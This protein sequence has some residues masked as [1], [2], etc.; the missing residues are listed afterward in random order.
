MKL[1][2]WVLMTMLACLLTSSI[3]WASPFMVHDVFARATV[4]GQSDGAAYLTIMNHGDQGDRLLAVSTPAAEAVELHSTTNVNGVAH[5]Q[6]ETS[7][8][9]PVHGTIRFQPG[10]YHLM[11]VGLKAPLKV[12]DTLK[13][14]LKF[15]HA[16]VVELKVPVKA[17]GQEME[18]HH[19]GGDGAEMSY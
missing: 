1:R 17:V 15:E 6:R 14:T 9:I 3:A 12:G 7:L 13:L 2:F 5:M 8:E 4:P 10:G 18:H 19:H 11:L 16:G